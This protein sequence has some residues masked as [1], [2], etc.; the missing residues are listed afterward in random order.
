MNTIP[1]SSRTRSNALARRFLSLKIKA[2]HMNETMTDPRLTSDTMD[3]IE[4]GSLS[5]VKYAKSAMQMN[6]D[7]RGIAQLQ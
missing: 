5:E 6:T 2:P 4:S 1:R 7:I 3:I